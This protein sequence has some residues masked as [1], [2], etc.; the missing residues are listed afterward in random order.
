MAPARIYPIRNRGGGGGPPGALDLYLPMKRI[1]IAIVTLVAFLAIVV[2]AIPFIVPDSFL[3]D[4]IAAKIAVWTGR[5]VTITGDPTLSLY[6]NLTITVTDLAVSNPE[7]MGGDAF[8]TAEAVRATMPVLPLLFGRTEFDQF[9]VVEPRVRLIT[10][11][12]G[13]TNWG[14]AGSGLMAQAERMAA[15]A[16][17]PAPPTDP[18]ATTPPPLPPPDIRFGRLRVVSGTIIVDDLATERREELSGVTLEMTWPTASAA[19]DGNGT[20]TWRG[21]RVDFNGWIGAPLMLLAGE[22]SRI[23]FALASTGLRAAFQGEAEDGGRR[24]AGNATITAPSLRRAL[25]WFGTPLEPGP[26]LAATAIDGSVVAGSGSIAFQNAAVELDGN[27]AIGDVALSFTG[28]RPRLAATLTTDRLD[29]SSYFEA[30][31]IAITGGSWLVAPTSLPVAGVLD[32]DVRVTAGEMLLGTAHIDNLAGGATLDHGAAT[33]AIDDGQLAGGT[34]RG[35]FEARMVDADLVANGS[36]ELIDVDTGSALADAATISAVDGRGGAMLAVGSRGKT[37]GE[38]ARGIGGTLKFVIRDGALHGIDV[39]EV[40]SMLAQPDD[41]P[42]R[43]IGGTTPFTALRG[44]VG[45]AQGDLVT[46]ALTLSAPSLSVTIGGRG[47]ILNGLLDARAEIV[48]EGKVVPVTITG[49]WRAPTISRDPDA[50]AGG[51]AA[52]VAQPTGG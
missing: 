23:R 51:E 26:T 25:T 3:K 8:L 18:A 12:A 6:P 46:E 4:R 36:V 47:S 50:A 13:Q 22:T 41:E 16:A 44:T 52:G 10:D 32:A 14:L 30:A 48:S 43:P 21:E 17:A 1:A 28:P 29:L 38:F 40:A 49:R 31:R 33:I 37:W 19:M 42:V 39:A 27:R 45:I 20:F 15:P 34:I 24:L 2:A 9:E 7:G 11:K 35:K 5:V